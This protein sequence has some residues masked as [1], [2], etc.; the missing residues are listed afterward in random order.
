MPDNFLIVTLDSCRWDVFS[1]ARI[2]RL[3][4]LLEVE[5]CGALATYTLP[6]HIAMLQGHF[7]HSSQS[8][9]YFNRFTKSLFRINAVGLSVRPSLVQFPA[10]TRDIVVGLRSRGYRTLVLGA[11]GWFK[12]HLL[13][14]TFEFVRFTGIDIEVQAAAVQGFVGQHAGEPQLI[15]WNVGET[16]DP[17]E[18]GGRI[19]EASSLRELMREGVVYDRKRAEH[20]VCKQSAALE[21]AAHFICETI[22]HLE[23]LGSN[24]IS[25]VCADHGECFGEDGCFGH[26]FY[27][28][29]VMKVPFGIRFP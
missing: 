5:E 22:V 27:H 6:S 26:G 15:L 9:P 19:E 17:F 20:L 23:N 21:Y 11:V 12:S 3:R 18:F 29:L 28:P 8:K 2:E 4:A 16:H 25:I 1:L 14:E 10:G 13:T 7:P 24:W